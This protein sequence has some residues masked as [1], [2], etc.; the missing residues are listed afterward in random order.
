MI[1]PFFDNRL[2]RKFSHV[3]G[4]RVY[5]EKYPEKVKETSKKYYE[6]NKLEIRRKSSL[7]S[8][9]NPMDRN[10]RY[11]YYKQY[12]KNLKEIVFNAYGGCKCACCGESGFEFLSL[13][14]INGGGNIHKKAV[15]NNLSIYRQLI[16]EGFP[17]GFQVLCMNC[18][19]AK[20][21][22]GTCPHKKETE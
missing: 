14:H 13:D 5:R 1:T 16:K 6:N 11:S 20:G 3:D 15:G 7:Y 19:W 12:T 18:N 22:Y 4:A 2:I 10:K 8:S 21:I 17:D 9:L